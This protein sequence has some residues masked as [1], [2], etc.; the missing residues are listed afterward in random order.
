MPALDPSNALD[1]FGAPLHAFFVLLGTAA[2]VA[3]FL[4]GA[5]RGR[6]LDDRLLAVLLG[7]LVCGALGARLA[8]VWRYLDTDAAP[9]VLGLVLGGGQSVLGG[10]AGAY[11]GAVATKRLIGYRAGTGDLFAPAAAVGIGIG[12]FGCLLTEA[13]GVP[14]GSRWGTVVDAA[15]AARIPGFPPRWIGVPLHPSFAY[16]IP[17]HFAMAVILWRLRARGACRDDLFKIYLA[18]YAPARFLLELVRGNPVVWHGLTRSQLFLAPSMAL[19]AA[20]F[21]R[22]PWSAEPGLPAAGPSR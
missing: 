20:Y 19:L 18:A 8:V 6:A 9:S 2:A 15:R 21:L 14:T 5:R 12:R 17:F 16:E 22:R 4:H 10:L 1:L 7:A 13:P 11:L 3:V